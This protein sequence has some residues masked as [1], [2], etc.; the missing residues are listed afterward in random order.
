MTPE[1][2]QAYWAAVLPS[3]EEFRRDLPSFADNIARTMEEAHLAPTDEAIG[4]ALFACIAAV[5]WLQLMRQQLN[6][7][8]PS[9]RHGREGPLQ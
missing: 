1:D 3:G 4:S 2:Q 9:V 6:N 5:H 8:D 7:D